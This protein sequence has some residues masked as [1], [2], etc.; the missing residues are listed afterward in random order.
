MQGVLDSADHLNPRQYYLAVKKLADTLSY[1]TDRSPFLGSGIEYVQSRP[2]MP[3]DPIRSIDWKVTARTGRYYVKE[4]EAPKRLTCYL[5][6]DTSA[7]MMVGSWKR[8]KYAVAV[9]LAGALALACLER[10]SPVGVLGLGSRDLLIKPSLSRQTVLQWMH[11]LRTFH[12]DEPTL[13][14]RRIGDLAPTLTSRALIFV[15]SDLHDPEGMSAMRLLAQQHDVAV[16]QLRDPAERG[17]AGA[18]FLRSREAETG[19]DF[20]TRSSKNWSQGQTVG[21]TLRRS[22]VDRLLVDID[23]P[24]EAPLRHFLQSRNLLGRAR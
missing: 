21:Q 19:K 5:L 23:K 14:N 11:M 4:F 22:G 16:I 15:L 20:V 3:G 17:I 6:I 9:H 8:T 2:Y 10:V 24:F 1:G 13:L 18:G 12:Y 7:S